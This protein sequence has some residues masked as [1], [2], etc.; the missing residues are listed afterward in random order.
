MRPVFFPRA[1]FLAPLF[2]GLLSLG[3]SGTALAQGAPA[4]VSP[5]HLALAKSVVEATGLTR[6]FAVIPTDLAT[7]F[8][9]SITLTRPELKAD[10]DAVIKDV[11]AGMANEQAVM[12]DAAGRAMA[13]Q[14]SEAELT[15]INAFFASAAGRKYVEK[16]PVMMD[17]V[18]RDLQV[19]QGSLSDI[20][21]TRVREGLKAR[22]KSL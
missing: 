18:F 10:L 6:S 1:R 7:R 2:A 16:Q 11:L 8:R 12:L 20:M 19:W 15:E 14:L 3:L 22:G 4:S 21:I 17:Q 9:D 13:A 5:T